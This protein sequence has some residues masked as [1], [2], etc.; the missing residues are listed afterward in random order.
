[1][2]NY[3]EGVALLVGSSG[4]E[5]EEGGPQFS[6]SERERGGERGEPFV[7]PR[8]V[9]D[10]DEDELPKLPERCIETR[11]PISSFINRFQI[12]LESCHQLLGLI[13]GL[14]VQRS[15]KVFVRDCE[16]FAIALAYLFCLA[17]ACSCLARFAYF[18][19]D[20]FT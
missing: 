6:H 13:L 9:D 7:F 19:S 20:L 16:K 15:A 18:L 5:Q 4:G 2:E 10:D 12:L 1:M 11:A 3:T 14:I 8:L 17:L